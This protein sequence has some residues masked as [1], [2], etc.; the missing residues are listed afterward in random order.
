MRTP[1]RA[2]P[3]KTPSSPSANTGSDLG[4]TAQSS[5]WHALHRTLGNQGM[6][7]LLRADVIQAKLRVGEPND[8]YE[9]EADR[10]AERVMRMPAPGAAAPAMSPVV[11][12][13]FASVQRKCACGG[14]PR[15]SGDCAECSKKK[16]GLQ[17]K[18]SGAVPYIQR[19]TGRSTGQADA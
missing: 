8:P 18:L 6:Q 19:F 4:P 1:T 9:Q 2:V 16:P 12:P 7:R 17:T 13:A 14:S 15:M 3:G 5:P 10:V 11:F